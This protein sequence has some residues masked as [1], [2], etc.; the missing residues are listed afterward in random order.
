MYARIVSMPVEDL[1]MDEREALCA[2]CAA[3]CDQLA[4]VQAHEW[5][6]NRATGTVSGMMKWSDAE[7]IAIGTES[8][9]MEV[10]RLREAD[11]I[12]RCRDIPCAVGPRAARAD[13][14]TTPNT[15]FVWYP[16]GYDPRG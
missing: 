8:L 4:G 3:L 13:T 7:A 1:S 16:P 10:A 2:E 9:R 11:C 6:V 15:G 5:S 12:L 14:D